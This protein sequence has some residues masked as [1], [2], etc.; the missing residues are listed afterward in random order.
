MEISMESIIAIA[1]L[2]LGGSGLTAIITWRSARK[3]AKAEASSAEFAAV[4]AATAA[5]KDM[6]DSY[7]TMVAD[8]NA[9]RESQRRYIDEMKQLIK[10]LKEDREHLRQER[11]EL[12]GRVEKLENG[13]LDL[14]SKVARYGRIANSMRPLLCGR[15]KCPDRISV[16]LS[17]EGM[18]E[19]T[20]E[21][22][23]TTERKRVSRKTRQEK[24]D[25][26]P[27]NEI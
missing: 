5:I 23:A 17:E 15:S 2:L 21:E 20:R 6:Q 10:D 12:R 9:D 27:S 24:A 25:I 19:E 18:V 14:S 8:V 3:K 4:Q 7:R 11:N 22:S 1:S 16:K 13:Q 26:E